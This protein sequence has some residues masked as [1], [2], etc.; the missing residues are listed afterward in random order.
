MAD[1]A[2]LCHT[3]ELFLVCQSKI[4]S[5]CCAWRRWLAGMVMAGCDANGILDG[6]LFDHA[7]SAGQYLL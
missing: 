5:Y 4:Y 1:A 7:D 6:N 2:D 3:F